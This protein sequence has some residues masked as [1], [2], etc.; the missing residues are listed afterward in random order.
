MYTYPCPSLPPYGEVV[1][2]LELI[3]SEPFFQQSHLVVWIAAFNQLEGSV[4]KYRRQRDCDLGMDQED[5]IYFSLGN[6]GQPGKA[7]ARC[8]DL[9]RAAGASVL[10]DAHRSLDR[11]K[12]EYSK[13]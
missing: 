9:M 4:V 12:D 3:R 2:L 6:R 8:H 13:W 11:G 7:R 10:K 1:P 5:E